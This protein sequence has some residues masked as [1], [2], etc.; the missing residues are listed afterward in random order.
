MIT[1]QGPIS[2]VGPGGRAGAAERRH[3]LRGKYL[4]EP[5]P[6]VI[7]AH[8]VGTLARQL[9]AAPVDPQIAYLLGDGLRHTPFADAYE[10]L[11]RFPYGNK[12]LQESSDGPRRGPRH[13]QEA[14]LPAGAG[15]GP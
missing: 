12:R 4:Y 14:R 11:D 2:L 3:L 10:V 7:R 1:P 8:L 15:R 5:D 9:D 6:A 13:H